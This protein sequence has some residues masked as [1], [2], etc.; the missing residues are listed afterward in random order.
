MNCLQCFSS[1]EILKN[2][3]KVCLEIDGKQASKMPGKGSNIFLTGHQKQ[4]NKFFC[5]LRWF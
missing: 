4:L 2:H 3:C 1:K 5:D